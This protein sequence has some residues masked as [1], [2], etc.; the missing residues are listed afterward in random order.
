MTSTENERTENKIIFDQRGKDNSDNADKSELSDGEKWQVAS[1]V[2]FI[3]AVLLG[4]ALF[5]GW[6][7]YLILNLAG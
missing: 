3:I 1:I 5:G 7:V 4:A 6:I 2:V